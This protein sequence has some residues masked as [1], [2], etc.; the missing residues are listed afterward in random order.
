MRRFVPFI[1]GAL[2]GLAV[3][4]TYL[5][6]AA[7]PRP[8]TRFRQAEFARMNQGTG[9]GL[10]YWDRRTQLFINIADRIATTDRLVREAS[11]RSRSNERRINALEN[12]INQ[13][14]N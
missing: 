2:V 12:S 7:A 8:P 3:S 13:L 10:Y 4:A 9:D 11:N 6:N 5:V 14:L 1:F